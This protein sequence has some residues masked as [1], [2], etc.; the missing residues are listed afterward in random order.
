MSMDARAQCKPFGRVDF[1]L[2]D[3]RKKWDGFDSFKQEDAGSVAIC[4]VR[5][6]GFQK[7][8]VYNYIH[9]TWHEADFGERGEREKREKR[10][11]REREIERER[12]R[13]LLQRSGTQR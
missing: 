6:L 4:C 5:V 12:E 8:G 2:G 7:W 13:Q 1:G 11:E 3:V 9:S 10:R